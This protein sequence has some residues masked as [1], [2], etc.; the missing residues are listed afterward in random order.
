MAY[1]TV[2]E[3]EWEDDAHRRAFESLIE[4]AEAPVVGRIVRVVGIDETGARAIEVWRSGD[5]AR[6]H[7]ERSA[8]ARADVVLPAPTRVYGFEVTSFDVAA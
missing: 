8:P 6:R 2:V 1:C 5:D 3:F 4:G 7:A